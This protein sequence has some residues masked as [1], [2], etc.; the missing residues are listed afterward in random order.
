MGSNNGKT[1]SRLSVFFFRQV[2]YP[3]PFVLLFTGSKAEIPILS[4]ES[5]ESQQT[6][7]TQLIYKEIMNL[8]RK[9]TTKKL[10]FPTSSCN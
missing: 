8:P 6:R 5:E 2:R 4:P 3:S 10:L 7:Y 1:E 9:L